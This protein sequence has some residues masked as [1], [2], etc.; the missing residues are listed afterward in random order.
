VTP[1][2]IQ[3]C[4]RSGSTLLRYIVDTH[5]AL[6]SPAELYL[7]RALEALKVTLE[8]STALLHPEGERHVFITTELRRICG[9]ILDDYARGKGKQG[10]CEKTPV[11]LQSLDLIDRVF[12]D[13]RH[14]CLHRNCMDVVHSALE[15]GRYGFVEGLAEYARRDPTNL[16]AA[17]AESWADKTE[18]LLAFERAHPDKCHRIKYEAVVFEPASVLPPMFKFLGV[19]WE[20]ALLDAVFR[21]PHDQGTGHAGDRKIRTTRK[22][23]RRVGSGS[24]ISRTHLPSA[25]LQ[26]VN[27]IL[28]QLEYPEVHEWW[29]K[30]PSPYL[31]PGVTPMPP[32][33]GGA[34]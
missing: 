31:P 6:C 13:A 5:S 29:D 19:G 2:F 26:R 12:P 33:P 14:V 30:A 27:G 3:A 18:W 28:R 15:A 11:N 20:P 4:E 24:T 21:T 7:G 23:E 34:R 32:P 16:V 17:M 9:G 1:L 22:I 8:R 10:W 25:L